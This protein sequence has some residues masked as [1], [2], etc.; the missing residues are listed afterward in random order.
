MNIKS[1]NLSVKLYRI[2]SISLII[3]VLIIDIAKTQVSFVTNGQ[4]ITSTKSWD[5]RLADINGDSNLDAY[6]EGKVWLNDGKGSFT[7]TDLA[8]GLF[9][10]F[11]DLNGD[12]FVDVVSNDSIYLNDGNYH[13]RFTN[14]LSS[15]IKMYNAALTDINNDGFIDIISCSTTTDRILLNNGKGNFINTDKSL[16]GWAQASY[17]SGDING[18]GYTDIYVAIPHEPPMGSHTPNVIWFGDKDGNFTSKQHDIPGA[19]SRSAILSDFNGDGH[20]DLYV[21]D[22]LSWGSIWLNDGK[23]NFIESKQKLGVHTGT[24]IIADFNN[25][26]YLDIFICQGEGPL[27][28]GA[29]NTVWINDGK[30]HF[31]DSKLRLGNSNSMAIAVG[32][33]NKDNRADAFVV[34]VKLDAQHG[35][36][37][38][39]CPVEI[40]L[41]T[42]FQCNYMNETKPGNTPQVFAK[43]KISIEGKN[44]HACSFSPDGRLFVFSR[45]PEKKSYIMVFNNGQWSDPKEAFFDGK[46]ASL[47]PYN[48][49]VF[50]YRNGEI[51]YNEKTVSGWSNA[52]S[53]GDSINTKEME[54]YPSVTY[55]GTLFFSRNGKWDEGYIMYS[56]LKNGKYSTPVNIGLP[57]N[58][59]GALHAYVAPDKSYM[60]FNSPREGSHT[61]LDL[62]I[63]FSNTDGSWTKP[64]NLGKEINSGADA[65]LC[66]TITPDG[67]YMFFTKLNLSTNT[68]TVY[69]VST[70][71]IETLKHDIK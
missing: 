53:A 63:S 2:I 10:G 38:V 33:I 66:P 7:K 44:T 67:K 19:E 14:Q 55:D 36:V 30:G 45:Y 62:W 16:G 40:W 56:T 52:I 4:S 20:L 15:D 43:D 6:F 42:P 48:D 71:F 50:Y 41:N 46:E 61:K 11:A 18:D 49:K 23:G 12:G 17:A 35:Y 24:A 5:I 37:A 31:T 58:T 32:D 39:P 21:S 22:A 9:A 64:Q 68:G 34:N 70:D 54:Y 8:F 47:S 3:I 57:I 13:Y 69:W 25:N 1:Y 29:P 28:N 51:Y 27:G 26:G 59:Q 65:I 60:I